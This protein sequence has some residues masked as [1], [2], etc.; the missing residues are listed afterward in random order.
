[1]AAST[2][3][4]FGCLHDA[5]RLRRGVRDFDAHPAP[6]TPGQLE[7]ALR[8][9]G[10]STELEFLYLDGDELGRPTRGDEPRVFVIA[11]ANGW[12]SHAELDGRRHSNLT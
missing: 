4:R 10:G 9:G 7:C 3:D 6:W 12:K 8:E 2:A 5:T 1:M 11:R